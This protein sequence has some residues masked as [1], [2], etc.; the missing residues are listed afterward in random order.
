MAP[1]PDVPPIDPD[2][3]PGGAKP[4]APANDAP[5]RATVLREI[6]VDLASGCCT[7]PLRRAAGGR[8]GMW[9][10]TLE[11]SATI[12]EDPTGIM[13]VT[14]PAGTP[15]FNWSEN[16]LPLAFGARA[17]VGYRPTACDRLEG[18]VGYSG[19]AEES[20]RQTARQFGFTPTPGGALALSP[21]AAATLTN[22][23]ELWNAELNWWRQLQCNRMWR[24]EAGAGARWIRYE[25]EASATDWQG[26]ASPNPSL[27][28][29]ATNSL[30]GAQAVGA[31]ILHCIPRVEVALIAKGIVGS[32]TRDLQESDASIVTGGPTTDAV[33]EQ[34][35]FGWAL[36][37][38]LAATFRVLPRVGI[39]AAYTILFLPEIARAETT[40]DFSQTMTGSL[41]HARA[42][43]DALI[44]AFF[45]GIRVDI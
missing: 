17:T 11:G 16:A 23:S 27:R 40:I 8:R 37:G 22:Q 43:D 9:D 20:S 14:P 3:D 21:A 29:Q 32:R 10:V 44:H 39:T 19:Q 7:A 24:I 42:T 13:G 30:L 36:E 5:L 28:N 31:F 2:P 41:Q 34:T 18:R 26:L 33:L 1:A 45:L 35:E 12:F 6:P 4:A 15:T 38:E 25:E